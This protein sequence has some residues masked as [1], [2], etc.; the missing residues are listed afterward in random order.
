MLD[1]HTVEDHLE[2]TRGQ[3]QGSGI[4]CGEVEATT[5]QALV[6]YAHTVAVPIENLEAVGL[7][8]EEDE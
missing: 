8:V 6:P 1:I 5:L 2:L 3:L 7:A 4:R